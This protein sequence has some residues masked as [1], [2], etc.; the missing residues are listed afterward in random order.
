MAVIDKTNGYIG[1]RELYYALG[2]IDD[3]ECD[4][5]TKEELR[6]NL[7]KFGHYG[8]RVNRYPV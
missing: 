7:L 2:Q 1:P 3:T 6:K 8:P 5:Y 4:R